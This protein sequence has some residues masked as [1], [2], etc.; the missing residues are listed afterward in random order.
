MKKNYYQVL[1]LKDGASLKE[2]KKAYKEYVMHYHPDMHGNS[3]FFKKRFQEVQEAYE[4]LMANSGSGKSYE[5]QKEGTYDEYTTGDVPFEKDMTPRVQIDFRRKLA[6]AILSVIISA[7][8][9]LI[10]MLGFRFK[11]P[12]PMFIPIVIGVY[13][14]LS[15]TNLLK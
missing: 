7:V 9:F 12:N 5:Y 3:E 2:I 10:L 14:I 15:K 13:Y 11:I 8:V 4:C 6:L 1:G